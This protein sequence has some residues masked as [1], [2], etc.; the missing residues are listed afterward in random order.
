MSVIE[1]EKLAGP[2]PPAQKTNGIEEEKIP[3]LPTWRVI[4]AM[5]RFRPWYWFVDLCSVL[6]FRV[7]WQLAPGLILREFFNL[8][9]GD[10]RVGMGIW[11]IVALLTAS[12]AG[13]IL[14]GYGFYY[15]DVPLFNDICFQLRKNLLR[16]ILN[17]PGASPLPDS[18]GEAVSRFRND[19]RE[20][21]LFVIWI[22]DILIGLLVVAIAIVLLAN[23]NL[24]ITLLALLPLVLIGIIAGAASSR[25]ER[26]RRASRQATGKVTGFI[27]EFFGAVQA[28]KVAAGEQNV[29]GHFNEL[30]EERRKL[31]V[32][33]RLFD[34]IL[35]SIYRNTGSLSTGVIL[36]LAGQ[37]MRAGTFTV[38]DFSLF[39][40]LLQSLSDLTTF[41]GMV[42]ARYK[43]LTVSVERMF[44][45]MQGAPLEA[46]VETGPLNL[47]E[48]P[49]PV[50][51]PANDPALRLSNL[52]VAGLSF[53]YPGSARGID[54]INL[55]LE[56]GSLTVI[57]G[58]VGSGKTT[59][60][61]VLLGLLPKASG[62][63]YWNGQAVSEPGSFFVPP[64]TA[65]T[66]QV[67]RLFSNSLRN[68]ILLGLDKGDTDI[69]DA[70]RLAVMEKDLSDLENGLETLVGP[71]GV[72]LS[73]GQM[74]R[75]A[76]AR[77]LVRQPDL[78]VFDDLSSALDVETER[79]LWDRLFARTNGNGQK[80]GTTCLVVS[81]RRP[82]L[83]RADQIIVMK[84][85]R[86]EASGKL[87]ELL[88]TS[89]EM[90]QLWHHETVAA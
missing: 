11:T 66:S 49:P 24:S 59:L 72:K 18:P 74:Q 56:R 52:E 65:Y 23:I 10:A 25:I 62:E 8:L 70:L 48:A 5:I 84:D 17:R 12:V 90:R 69:Q 31:T 83:R 60:L 45:L 47:N 75:A 86:V 6:I 26:Y 54:N 33:E 13:R 57:T 3:A 35:E 39:I 73:G 16:H 68:N 9:T 85:G 46:L 64:R 50:E 34:E 79:Q 20:I 88:E 7:F 28:V 41:A 71:R 82:V 21:P 80:A 36:I 37:S 14:G 44:R 15:A 32:R 78:L 55:S 1:A 40:Y 42:A 67:P 89:E 81:H 77:M 63:I 30:N 87:D 53:N 29:I 43:Q 27:G 2:N 19:V 58:Q 51:P 4:L 22:N 38:G 61:R 76:A